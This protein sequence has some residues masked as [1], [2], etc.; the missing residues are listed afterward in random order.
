MYSFLIKCPLE[1]WG[2]S[3]VQE[4][5]FQR[6]CSALFEVTHMLC[7]SLHSFGLMNDTI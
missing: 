2:L 7:M 3:L 1:G 6:P 4:L 5:V